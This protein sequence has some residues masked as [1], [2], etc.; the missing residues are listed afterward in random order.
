MSFSTGSCVLFLSPHSHDVVCVCSL[1]HELKGHQNRVSTVGVNAEGNALCTGSWDQTLM[2]RF[3]CVCVCARAR[4][5][6]KSAVFLVFPVSCL[7]CFTPPVCVVVRWDG[8]VLV[9]R[10]D[11]RSHL[12]QIWA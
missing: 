11:V 2:V 8:R 4:G 10:S 9:V 1:F 7:S 3:V 5:V 12:L 6:M